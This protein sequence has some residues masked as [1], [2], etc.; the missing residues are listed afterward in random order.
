MKK[1]EYYEN[2]LFDLKKEQ[3]RESHVL[4]SLNEILTY[5]QNKKYQPVDSLE[6][7]IQELEGRRTEVKSAIKQIE[8]TVK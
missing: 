5:L 3:G 7:T 2:M 6:S 8:E 1:A 4:K